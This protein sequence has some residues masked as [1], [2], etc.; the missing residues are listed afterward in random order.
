MRLSALQNVK[1]IYRVTG[2]P[3]NFLTALRH[4]TWGFKDEK[5]LKNHW[6]DLEPGDII[7]FHSAGTLSHFLKKKDLLSRIVGFGVVGNDFFVGES[8]LWIEE[9]EENRVIYPYRFHFSEIYLFADIPPLGDWE[10]QNLSKSE[11]TS[12]LLKRLLAAGIPLSDMPSFPAMGSYSGIKN[13]ETKEILL[14]STR[15]LFGYRTREEEEDALPSRQ[16]QLQELHN[17]ADTFR[18]TTSLTQFE[19]IAGRVIRMDDGHRQVDIAQLNQAEQAHAAI[20]SQLFQTL[21]ERGYDCYKNN[22]IDLLAVDRAQG[23]SLLI[24]AKSNEAGN[25]RPQARKGIV[26]LFEYNYF[27]V[28]RFKQEQDLRL[29]QEHQV[30]AFSRTPKD[31]DYVGFINAMKIRTLAVRSG[32]IEALGDLPNVQELV[33]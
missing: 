3:E 18:H 30:L 17:Q 16:T 14:S 21:R 13:A 26:Q 20:L 12:A 33:G 31:T 22:H 5:A 32:H 8:P 24:E 6:K 15:D 27:E 7:F 11:Q 9:F 2:T 4:S 19:D 1:S 29:S 23:R 25:F 10:S 28:N